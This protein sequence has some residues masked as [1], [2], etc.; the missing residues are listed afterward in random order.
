MTRA[1]IER[2]IRELRHTAANIRQ[3][4]QRADG[5]G[6]YQEEMKRAAAMEAEAQRLEESLPRDCGCRK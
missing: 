3:C 5:R 6:I 1:Q 2:R 4:A